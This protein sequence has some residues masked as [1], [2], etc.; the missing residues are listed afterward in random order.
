MIPVTARDP[1]RAGPRPARFSRVEPDLRE[2][3][4]TETVSVGARHTGFRAARIAAPGHELVDHRT[5]SRRRRSRL[6]RRWSRRSEDARRLGHW[7]HSD[8]S[9]LGTRRPRH[10]RTHRRRAIRRRTHQGRWRCNLRVLSWS[11][12]GS[13]RRGDV[14]HGRRERVLDRTGDHR[15][16][17]R[18][19][20]DAQLLEQI[21]GGLAA[22]HTALE[23]K[24]PRPQVGEG[25]ACQHRSGRICARSRP[26]RVSP[27]VSRRCPA[28][29]KRSQPEFPTF[30]GGPDRP[31][32][33][34]PPRSRAW[35]RTPAV[36]C[37][38]TSSRGPR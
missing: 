2:A 26:P 9:V 35:T 18:P 23:R 12:D 8:R 11:S 3:A 29:R 17:T 15:G 30:P 33:R 13:R 7:R 19:R 32:A 31:S 14:R 25:V 34:R 38:W 5:G 21:A 22:F 1:A 36:Q 6:V 37:A 4:R 24:G 28:G 27:C 16:R 20:G 10:R